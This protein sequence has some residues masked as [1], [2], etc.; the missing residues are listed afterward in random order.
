MMQ[1][2]GSTDHCAKHF[3]IMSPDTLDQCNDAQNYQGTLFFSPPL[4]A[5]CSRGDLNS[6][7][8]PAFSDVETALHNLKKE[9]NRTLSLIRL[10]QQC[11]DF[12]PRP[13]LIERYTSLSCETEG[14]GITHGESSRHYLF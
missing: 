14:K 4:Q 7:F 13:R 9:Q 3:L 2:K 12:R 8:K 1:E 10:Q 6:S 5:Y 11:N